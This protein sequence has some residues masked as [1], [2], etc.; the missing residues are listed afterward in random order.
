MGRIVQILENKNANVQRQGLQK[1]SSLTFMSIVLRLRDPDTNKVKITTTIIS[2]F[3]ED[4]IIKL[5]FADS[6]SL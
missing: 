2:E 6:E 5:F 1:E 4:L 3:Y